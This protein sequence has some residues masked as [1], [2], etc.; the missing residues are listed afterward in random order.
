M[1]VSI[2][3]FGLLLVVESAGY[4]AHAAVS[5]HLMRLQFSFSFLSVSKQFAMLVSSVSWSEMLVIFD[6]NRIHVMLIAC[7]IASRTTKQNTKTDCRFSWLSLRTQSLIDNFFECILNATMNEENV[8]AFWGR[9]LCNN[10]YNRRIFSGIFIFFIVI[11][12]FLGLDNILFHF[13]YAFISKMKW[14]RSSSHFPLIFFH[15]SFAFLLE[16]LFYL[17]MLLLFV[18]RRTA[19]WWCIHMLFICSHYFE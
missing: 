16:F 3:V 5:H 13:I 12:R 1:T 8:Y 14:K 11:F 2:C 15:L 7:T 9:F 6:S 19:L 17:W 18:H 4:N 10:K